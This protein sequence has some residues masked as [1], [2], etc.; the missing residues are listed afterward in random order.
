MK[1]STYPPSTSATSKATMQIT[2][3]LNIRSGR[4]RVFLSKRSPNLPNRAAYICQINGIA[5]PA[6][7]PEII[8][9]TAQSSIEATKSGNLSASSSSPCKWYNSSIYHPYSL[10]LQKYAALHYR[11]ARSFFCVR[12]VYDT[13]TFSVRGF[14]KCYIYFMSCSTS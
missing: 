7:G 10:A 4:W 11:Y 5:F 14:F 9:T 1:T 13:N 3:P 6:N 2:K 8:P 12:I